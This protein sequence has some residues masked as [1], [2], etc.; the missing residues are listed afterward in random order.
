PPGSVNFSETNLDIGQNFDGHIYSRSKFEA[1]KAVYSAGR[2]GLKATVYRVGNLVGR[3]SDGLFQKNI[4]TNSFYNR[5][6]AVIRLKTY[7]SMLNDW[8]TEMSPVDLC[9][10]SLV[11]LVRLNDSVHHCFHLMN[12]N[13]LSFG[14]LAENLKV[15]GYSI[16]SQDYQSFSNR[17]HQLLKDGDPQENIELSRIFYALEP[18]G[19][20]ENPDENE[21]ESQ[22]PI[23][24]GSDGNSNP[25]IN[26]SIDSTF[27]REVLARTGFSW[28]EPD[29]AYIAKMLKHGIEAGYFP[30]P[31]T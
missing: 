12:P 9:S 18:A 25:E 22:T 19:E 15:N 27:T 13:Y 2:Q 8:Q 29:P 21:N 14:G 20:I 6:K 23:P 1:E 5:I 24:N 31:K 11:N 4:E 16:E 7:P 26:T 17:V 30:H 10:E 28:R 3:Y